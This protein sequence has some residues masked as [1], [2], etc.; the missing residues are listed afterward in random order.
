MYNEYKRILVPVD[1][2]KYAEAALNKAVEVAIRNEG[3]LDILSVIN[4]TSFGFTYG[5]LSGD[6]ITQMVDGELA[7]LKG[8]VKQITTKTGFKN[9]HMHVRFGNPR[10]VITYDFTKDYATDLIM[11]GATGKNAT[12]RLLVGSVA[13]YVNSHASCDV[14]I[15][16]TNLKNQPLT[17]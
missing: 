2:S 7:Y 9:I 8:L 15:V 3:R 14:M 17:D 4:T 6:A 10:N 13:S 16:R 12:E 1:G 5:V 11:M